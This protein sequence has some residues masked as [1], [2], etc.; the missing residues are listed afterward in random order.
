VTLASLTTGS[1]HLIKDYLESDFCSDS[2]KAVREMKTSSKAFPHVLRILDNFR[3]GLKRLYPVALQVSFFHSFLEILGLILNTQGSTARH[4]WK[5]GPNHVFQKIILKDQIFQP[6]LEDAWFSC[7]D[8]KVR[9]PADA[10]DKIIMMDVHTNIFYGR[11]L[12]G[13]DIIDAVMDMNLVIQQ[14]LIESVFFGSLEM[15]NYIDAVFRKAG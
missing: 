11:A 7:L 8:E 15:V 2:I 10:L 5:M 14:M 9:T 3:I 12:F 1:L 6:Y 13:K 4:E